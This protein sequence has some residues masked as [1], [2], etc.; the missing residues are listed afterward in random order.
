VIL[1][2]GVALSFFGNLLFQLVFISEIFIV[3]WIVA[4]SHR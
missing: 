4:R 1:M 3:A 2:H